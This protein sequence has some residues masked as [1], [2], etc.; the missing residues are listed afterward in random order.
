MLRLRQV[1]LT[2]RGCP[3]A[4]APQNDS[5][6]SPSEVDKVHCVRTRG[7]EVHSLLEV[8]RD[9]LKMYWRYMTR[10]LQMYVICILSFHEIYF[11]LQFHEIFNIFD[12]IMAQLRLK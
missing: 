10:D 6:V 1:Q 3:G 7:E 12:L 5:S 9:I 11:I 2:L 8:S 4:T